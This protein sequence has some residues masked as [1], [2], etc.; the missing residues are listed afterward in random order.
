MGVFPCVMTT[1]VKCERIDYVL[2]L[3]VT[4]LNT[5]SNFFS[6][7]LLTFRTPNMLH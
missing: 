2:K 7:C 3:T 6:Y 1:E 4:L 5:H